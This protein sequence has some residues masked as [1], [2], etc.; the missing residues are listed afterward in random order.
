MFQKEIVVLCSLAVLLFALIAGSTSLVVR[1]VER[2]ARMVARDTLPGLVN[3]GEAI[4]RIH[5]NWF[6]TSQLL[7]LSD[8]QARVSLVAKVHTNST[9]ELWER[10]SRAIFE[11]EDQQSFQ[12]MQEYRSTFVELRNRFFDLITAGK[13]D[14]ARQLYDTQLATAFEKY[15][16]AAAGLFNS[17]AKLG[18]RRADNILNI[19]VWTPHLLGGFCVLIF[20]LGVFVGF[21]A[22]LGGFSGNWS[23]KIATKTRSH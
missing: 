4:H 19:S 15:R 7:S 3:A 14:E 21:K 8:S 23:D 18:R 12:A 16:A 10:Y 5:E 20:L 1:A 2:D 11:P 17:S 22:T 6:Y 9:R 13:V